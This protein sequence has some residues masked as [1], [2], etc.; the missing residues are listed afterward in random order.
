[1]SFGVEAIRL[2]HQRAGTDEQITEPGTRADAG[3]AVM[4]CVAGREVARLLDRA[5][6]EDPIMG[7]E[8][9]VELHDAG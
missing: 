8:H 6:D 9:V 5:I 7:H 1:M 3:M 2:D 4:S